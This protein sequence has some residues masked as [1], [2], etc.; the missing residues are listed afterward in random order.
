[1]RLPDQEDGCEDDQLEVETVTSLNTALNIDQQMP[2]QTAGELTAVMWQPNDSSKLLCLQGDR[3][4]SVDIGEGEPK[5]ILSSVHSVR[6]QTRLETA[7]WN[8]HRNYHQY[9][10]VCG[11]QVVGWDTRTGDQAWSLHNIVTNQSIRSL[12]FNPNKQYYMV[13]GC[14][15][16]AVSVWD[17]RSADQALTTLRQ[18]SHWVWST[19]YNTYHDQLL[20]SAGSD[21]KVVMTSVASLSSEPYGAIVDEEGDGKKLEDGVISVWTDHEDSVYT[22]EWSSADPWTFAS[23][24]YDGRLVIGHVPQHV[25]F[26]IL[27]L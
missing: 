22:A 1:M 20:L 9:A 3:A 21:S 5:Q 18:H 12:D 7:R 14:D 19:R 27:N 17:V 4:V 2:G 26:N 10:T 25:K 24:S 15:D 6:G 23:L 13:T 16:G 8:P 11:A